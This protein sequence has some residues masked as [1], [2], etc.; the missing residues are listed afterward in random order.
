MPFKKSLITLVLIMS[1]A[2]LAWAMDGESEFLDLAP[3][4][5]IDD[6]ANAGTCQD[7]SKSVY[8]IGRGSNEYSARRDA[9][10]SLRYS[11][12]SLRSRCE[13]NDGRFQSGSV[14]TRCR[15]VGNRFQCESSTRVSCDCRL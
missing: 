12:S 14:Y 10:A 13:I 6:F 11:V 3:L 7:F 5:A 2:H 1:A 8:E 15:Q 4:T 9:E